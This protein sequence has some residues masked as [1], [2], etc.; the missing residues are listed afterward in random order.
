VVMGGD[1]GDLI[2]GSSVVSGMNSTALLEGLAAGRRTVVPRFE[3]A[4]DPRADPFFLDLGDAVETAD[5]EEDLFVR[6]RDAARNPLPLTET[7]GAGSARELETW[8]GNADGAAGARVA[9]AIAAEV[10]SAG[11]SGQM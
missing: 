2:S 5:S 6:L 10:A 9:R 1:P 4:L 7:L 8:A 3:E 11:A